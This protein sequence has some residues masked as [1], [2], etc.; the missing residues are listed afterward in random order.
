MFEH[1]LPNSPHTE[2]LTALA[3][4]RRS[5][6]AAPKQPTW[7]WLVTAFAL[8]ATIA[9]IAS[10]FVLDNRTNMRLDQASTDTVAYTD[11]VRAN[12][13]AHAGL[14]DA[15]VALASYT[16]KLDAT[17]AKANEYPELFSSEALGK[18]E[19][20]VAAYSAE[21]DVEP[22]PAEL[23]QVD[24]ESLDEQYRYGG[25]SYASAA[26]QI[27]E[28]TLAFRTQ[29]QQIE[30]RTAA[31][32]AKRDAVD[33]SLVALASTAVELA[34]D[35]NEKYPKASA[36]AIAMSADTLAVIASIADGGFVATADS[37]PT[38]ALYSYVNAILAADASHAKTVE[39]ERLAE[40]TRLAEEARKAEE[41]KQAAALQA[42]SSSSGSSSSSSSGGTSAPTYSGGGSKESWMAAAGIAESDWGYVDYIVTRESGWNPNAVNPSSGASGLVQ[43]LPCGKVPG[44]CF[45]PVDNLSWADGYAKSRYG[46]WAAA[47]DFWTSN[48]WW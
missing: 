27:A 25:E 1:P 41:A 7:A 23:G 31:L 39:A 40:E 44:S 21:A 13:A 33:A 30:Q 29:T 32:Q 14:E 5:A 38:A 34:P 3:P 9:L 22:T 6:V 35:A 37:R 36:E 19:A 11:A 12:A 8:L 42:A 10:M 46:S 17:V 26:A 2:P 45:D 18:F 24:L 47:Y 20:A 43:A 28:Q 4:I 15:T 16:S 48:H